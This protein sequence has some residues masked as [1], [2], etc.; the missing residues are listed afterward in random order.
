[1]VLIDQSNVKMWGVVSLVQM[2]QK[3]GKLAGTGKSKPLALGA[4]VGTTE[5]SSSSDLSYASLIQVLRVKIK[6]NTNA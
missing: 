5:T 6:V 1:M 3:E 4:F 2:L